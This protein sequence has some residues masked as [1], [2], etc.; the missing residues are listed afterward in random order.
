MHL[1][2]GCDLSSKYLHLRNEWIEINC[3]FL[4]QKRPLFVASVLF[5][6]WIV[7]H[8]L[9]KVTISLNSMQDVIYVLHYL[10]LRAT[11]QSLQNVIHPCLN[12]FCPLF[13]F[14]CCNKSNYSPFIPW[15]AV[16]NMHSFHFCISQ[17]DKQCQSRFFCYKELILEACLCTIFMF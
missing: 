15:F 3:H 8:K 16:F 17:G 5:F 9:F 2:I 1:C 13:H 12:L 7:V 11:M 14:H 6:V 10:K 4:L